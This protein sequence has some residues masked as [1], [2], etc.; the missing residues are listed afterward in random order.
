[1]AHTGYFCTRQSRVVSSDPQRPGSVRVVCDLLCLV[2][3]SSTVCQFM[4]RC[5][6]RSVPYSVHGQRIT[7][8]FSFSAVLMNTHT[9]ELCCLSY[10]FLRLQLFHGIIPCMFNFE[11]T[12]WFD[13]F[14]GAICFLSPIIGCCFVAGSLALL[15]FFT[16]DLFFIFLLLPKLTRTRV[17]I[18]L[19]FE[20][21]RF[22]TFPSLKMI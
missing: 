17:I 21:F 10:Y 9:H 19:M 2:L 3:F 7:V 6:R 14:V 5:Y 22:S 16:Y 4:R 12:N 8:S 13:S 18:E 20:G 1:M 15:F 11:S